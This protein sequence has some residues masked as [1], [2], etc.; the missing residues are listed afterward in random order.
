MARARSEE[1]FAQEIAEGR[2]E[3]DCRLDVLRFGVLRLADLALA[4]Y[5][6]ARGRPMPSS[7]IL[8]RRLNRC[9]SST[10]ELFLV[11]GMHRA[12][13]I[14]PGAPAHQEILG[15]MSALA[16]HLKAETER[17]Q[18]HVLARLLLEAIWPPI[19]ILRSRGLSVRQ[20]PGKG[21]RAAKPPPQKQ[22]QPQ[23]PWKQL[24]DALSKRRGPSAEKAYEALEA[25][26]KKPGVIPT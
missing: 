25:E 14:T 5:R 11:H 23:K 18:L 10:D 6:R 21:Q 9:V 22:K 4:D 12:P 7:K 8:A 13:R 26:M 2:L 16:W 15:L 17:P 24:S 20:Q 1:I 3:A 19:L